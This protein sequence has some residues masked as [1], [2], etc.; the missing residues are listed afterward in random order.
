MIEVITLQTNSPLEN[1]NYLIWDKTNSLCFIIDPFDGKQI[2]EKLDQLQVNK[3]IILL[4]HTHADHVAGVDFLNSQFQV[5]VWGHSLCKQ[6]G[7]QLERELVDGDQ[8]PLSGGSLKV[9][10]VPGHKEEHIVFYFESESTQQFLIAGDTLFFAGV[11]NCKNGGNPERLF[12]S[13]KKLNDEINNKTIIYP[14]HD[15]L[16]TNLGFALSVEPSNVYAKEFLSSLN[17][18]KCMVP[19]TMEQERKLN[20]F[21][22]LDQP[23]IRESVSRD[24]RNNKERFIKLRSLRDRW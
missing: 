18:G 20:P 10:E 11:G 5:P 24:C 17:Q 19:T 9:L 22:R 12:E 3:S 13:I 6:F 7:F 16:K 1:L 21:L 4:T 2:K 15:Y 14:G 23:E 8:I